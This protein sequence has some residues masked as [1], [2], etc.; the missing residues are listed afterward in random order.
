M[1]QENGGHRPAWYLAGPMT[2]IPQFNF[3][4]FFRA[5]EKLRYI[6]YEIVS[7]AELDAAK[8]YPALTGNLIVLEP[9][10]CYVDI[11][12][13]E[14]VTLRIIALHLAHNLQIENVS[15][16]VRGRLWVLAGDR[17][18]LELRHDPPGAHRAHFDTASNVCADVPL[19]G[20]ALAVS[21]E[22]S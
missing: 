18:V 19:Y 17:D 9:E 16:E 12:V 13:A 10:H 3:P 11:P 7:P 2:G 8:V 6:G 20:R 4:L 5:T 1:S 14:V 15:V 22:K 21:T